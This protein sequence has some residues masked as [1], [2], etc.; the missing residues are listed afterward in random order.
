M[1]NKLSK[2][3]LETL[4]DEPKYF[5]SYSSIPLYKEWRS[6]YDLETIEIDPAMDHPFKLVTRLKLAHY[7]DPDDDLSCTKILIGIRDHSWEYCKKNIEFGIHKGCLF[8][9]ELYDYTKIEKN[10]LLD[11]IELILGVNPTKNG[12]CKVTLTTTNSEGKVLSKLVANKCPS[13]WKGKISPGP[14][15]NYLRIE[16]TYAMS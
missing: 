9:N 8:I 10:S 12:F 5:D 3:C 16:G 15:F 14:H 11:G 4:S 7:M 13:D 1:T 2:E 6:L